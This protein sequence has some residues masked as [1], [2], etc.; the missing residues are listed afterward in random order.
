MTPLK[1]FKLTALLLACLTCP[2]VIMAQAKTVP[3]IPLNKIASLSVKGI[4]QPIEEDSLLTKTIKVEL[5]GKSVFMAK[6]KQAVSDFLTAKKAVKKIKGKLKLPL[7]K[8]TKTIA[9]NDVLDETHQVYDYL[10]TIDFLNVYVISGVYWED[11][12]YK[13]ISKADGTETDF[14][15]FPYISANKKNIISIYD[16]PYSNESE[17]D[18]YKIVNKK[19]QSILSV[20]F[21]NWIPALE[22]ERMFWS[23]DGNFYVPILYSDNYLDKT[24]NYSTDYKYIR[25]SLLKK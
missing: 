11:L 21:K 3:P 20:T 8:G 5:I 2:S 6:K 23:A 4:E 10:G 14:P 22:K 15:Y 25:I 1:G 16:D 12:D 9:D 17:F 24:G 18:L 7:Q 13:F 19:P